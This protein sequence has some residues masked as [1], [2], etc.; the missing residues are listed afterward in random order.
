LK[1]I[2]RDLGTIDDVHGINLVESNGEPTDENGHGTNCAGVIG[3]ECGNKLGICGVNWKTQIMPLKVLNAGGF[4]T[5]L[6]ASQAINYAI[7]RK[8][9]GVNLRIIN[10]SW[11]L[12]E[13]SRAL[14]D[15]IHKASEAGILFI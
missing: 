5:V 10:V 15:V 7:D 12:T 4:G 14:E 9:A 2:D 13:H 1:A 11:G 3:A 8:G 6:G